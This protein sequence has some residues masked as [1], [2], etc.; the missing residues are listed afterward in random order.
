MFRFIVFLF[1]FF[2]TAQSLYDNGHDLNEGRI[3][4]EKN[5]S[6]VEPGFAGFKHDFKVFTY[7]G[8]VLGVS[9][10][11]SSVGI[12]CSPNDLTNDQ[13]LSIVADY[14]QKPSTSN[15]SA[16]VLIFDALESAYPCPTKPDH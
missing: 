13:I 8:Y 1:I 15:P 12:V 3:A 6:E 16:A 7:K 4:Y 2:M 14:I 11:V 9:K 10:F 5:A